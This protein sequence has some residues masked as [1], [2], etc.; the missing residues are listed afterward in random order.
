MRFDCDSET[1][2][3]TITLASAASGGPAAKRL[4]SANCLL[5]EVAGDELTAT[6]G[7]DD[8]TLS[9]SV[10][11]NGSGDGKALLPAKLI[12][13]VAKALPP[14]A[15]KITSNDNAVQVQCGTAEFEL[16]VMNVDET[17][18]PGP[19]HYNGSELAGFS[20]AGAAQDLARVL[21]AASKDDSRQIL[22]GVLMGVG[23]ADRH[24]AAT[25]SYRLA[26]AGMSAADS[27][28]RNILL[29]RRAAANLLKLLDDTAET[30]LCC[31]ENTATFTIGPVRLSVR[32]IP[33]DYPN[34]KALVA[35]GD[36][37]TRV[38]CARDDLIYTVKRIRLIA[39]DG[40]VTLELADGVVSMRAIS[41][42]AGAACETVDAQFEGVD[43]AV[44]FNPTY[45]LEGLV[46]LP[47]D[48]AR[49]EI[50]GPEKAVRLH[51]AQSDFLY[52]L[53][54]TKRG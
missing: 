27:H 38:E 39:D 43:V 14:G 2:S 40:P 30:R 29:P 5:L 10:P 9:S 11:V 24:L 22:T 7:D 28:D 16:V 20:F 44:A 52:L 54:P 41:Q 48:M 31:N 37:A 36:G 32:L 18:L 35:T 4:A 23:D 25:D 8:M 21:P 33:G 49:F 42:Q 13:Q 51:D 1:L 15:V 47:G 26:V 12:S 46:A 19:A 45:L 53:M 3:K 50:D 17:P 6:A 34:Y